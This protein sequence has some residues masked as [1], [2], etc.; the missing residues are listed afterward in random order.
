MSPSTAAFDLRAVVVSGSAVNYL[1][2]H[3]ADMQLGV[4][5]GD[6]RSDV[7]DLLGPIGSAALHDTDCSLLIRDRGELL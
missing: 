3:A 5:G 2:K 4:V 1:V 6:D 7:G